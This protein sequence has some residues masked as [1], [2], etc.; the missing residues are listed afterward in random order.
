MKILEVKDLSVYVRDKKILSSLN[1]YVGRGERFGIVGESGTGKSTLINTISSFLDENWRK[2]GCMELRCKKLALISQDY[3][4]NFNPMMKIGSHFYELMGKNSRTEKKRVAISFLEKVAIDNPEKVLESYSF[5]L[6]GGMLQRINIALALLIDAD[7]II[8]D[9]ITSSLD[10][11]TQREVIGVLDSVITSEKKSLIIVSHD[12]KLLEELK[13]DRV[14]IMY[15]GEILECGKSED[16]LFS[17]Q[18]QYG[19]TLIEANLKKTQISTTVTTD[20]LLLRVSN[21]YKNYGDRTILKNINFSLHSN[22]SIGILGKS[23]SGK[24]TLARIIVGL[25]KQERGDIYYRGEFLDERS[26]EKYRRKIQIIFQNSREALNPY[27]KIK[28]ILK[29]ANSDEKKIEKVLDEVG[30]PYESLDKYPRQFSGGQIQRICI[31]RALLSAPEILIL[32]EPTSSL[33]K[34]TQWQILHLLKKLKE[35]KK[36]SYILISHNLEVIKYICDLG[37]IINRGE[38]VYTIENIS[39]FNEKNCNDFVKFF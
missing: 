28:D 34:A 1:F 29:D 17:P 25:E 11:Y 4:A 13:V 6:S 35:N 18:S 5:E 27:R 26:Y 23:G 24:S 31:A 39:E 15:K 38:I 3:Y 9:E 8:A 20:N 37:I 21:L 30:L 12:F 16:I 36:I 14:A 7:L 33:D 10:S 32:D 2:D 22:Q 19:K